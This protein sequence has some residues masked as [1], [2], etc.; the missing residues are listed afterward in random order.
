MAQAELK[1][2]PLPLIDGES[3]Y[4]LNERQLREAKK[5]VYEA[6][7]NGGRLGQELDRLERDYERNE[8]AALA[9]VLIDRLLREGAAR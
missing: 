2:T 6:S 1:G 3:V 7:V 9:F 5:L 8:R 4:C